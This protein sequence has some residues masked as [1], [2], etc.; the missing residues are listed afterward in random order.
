MSVD[1]RSAFSKRYGSRDLNIFVRLLR[2]DGLNKKEN[3]LC[4]RV[5]QR[6]MGWGLSPTL[7]LCKNSCALG[8][9]EIA[10]MCLF[11]VLEW[12]CFCEGTNFL[13][14]YKFRPFIFLRFPHFKICQ[15]FFFF[16]WFLELFFLLISFHPIVTIFFLGYG[17]QARL[18]Q[19]SSRVAKK[20]QVGLGRIS[21]MF[22]DHSGFCFK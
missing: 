9:C 5:G 19:F 16:F 11:R 6:K 22:V 8:S 15:Y 10:F 13:H 12:M 17:P 21:L 1:S 2:G 18:N 20:Y 4:K 14:F 3:H 7:C